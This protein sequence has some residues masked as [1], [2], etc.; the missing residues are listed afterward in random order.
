MNSTLIIKYTP[1]ILILLFTV[2]GVPWEKNPEIIMW[3]GKNY[4]RLLLDYV[5]HNTKRD[6]YKR[7]CIQ[8]VPSKKRKTKKYYPDTIKVRFTK[9]VFEAV[10]MS[11]YKIYNLEWNVGHIEYRHENGYWTGLIPTLDYDESFV[12]PISIKKGEI[13]T[14]SELFLKLLPK[15]VREDNQGNKAQVLL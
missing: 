3:K 6:E 7:H 12:I 8:F 4:E 2:F 11:G 9:D 15:E 1:I 10:S 13:P 5:D 14:E